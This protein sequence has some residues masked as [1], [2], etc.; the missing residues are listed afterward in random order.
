M[1][2]HPTGKRLHIDMTLIG[3]IEHALFSCRE[4]A[5]DRV[6]ALRGQLL[7]IRILKGIVQGFLESG[8]GIDILVPPISIELSYKARL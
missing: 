5:L 3:A 4:N 1:S 8:L 7:F 6:E 2:E